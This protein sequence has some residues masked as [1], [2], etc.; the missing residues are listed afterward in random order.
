MAIQGALPVEFGVVFPHGAYALG[1]EAI[2]NFETKR[3]EVDKDTGLPMW[4]VDV[5]DADPEAR[6]KAK[7]VKVK[8][9]AEVCPTLP[10]EAP[11]LPFRPVE[12]EGMAVRP[13][14]EE[15]GRGRNRIAYS[16]RARGVKAPGAAG[17]RSTSAKDAA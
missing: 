9:A 14:I 16:L 12:F 15:L 13:Y 5:I 8:I 4:A 11:G 2:T 7:S 17:R 3:P 1:V 6:G 10:D